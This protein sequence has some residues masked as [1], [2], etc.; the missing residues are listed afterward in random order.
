MLNS[1][2]KLRARKEDAARLYGAIVA[3]AREPAFYARLGVADTIDGR[4]DLLALHA[5]LVLDRLREPGINDLSQALTDTI[6]VGFEEGM[7]DLGTG[8]MGMGRKLKAFAD[9]FYGR[10]AAYHA[11]E[12]EAAMTAAVVR[13]LYRG[14]ENPNAT[15]IARY[16]LAARE[17]LAG[18]DV[19][20]QLDF[21]PLP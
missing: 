15:A 4:F 17:R 14:A 19:A 2:R 10:L 12:D 11:C 1:F 8:D 18:Q 3:R 13:N 16:A 5:W 6:F 7:R 9:A 20:A 21:G